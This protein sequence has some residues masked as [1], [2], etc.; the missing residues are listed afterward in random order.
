MQSQKIV[1]QNNKGML[2]EI[3]EKKNIPGIP[4]WIFLVNAEGISIEITEL[5]LPNLLFP[6]KLLKEPKKLPEKF[7]KKCGKNFHTHFQRKFL[8]RTSKRVKIHE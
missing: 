8:Q 3:S 6:N 7:P 4:E 2:L 5:Y 1:T